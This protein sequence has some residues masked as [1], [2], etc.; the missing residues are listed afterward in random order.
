MSWLSRLGKKEALKWCAV[1]LFC[2]CIMGVVVIPALFLL[3]VYLTA[4]QEFVR[5]FSLPWPHKDGEGYFLSDKQNGR[6]VNHWSVGKP[7]FTSLVRFGAFEADHSNIPSKDILDSNLPVLKPNWSEPFEVIKA[8]WIGHA[9]VWVD[10]KGFS[11]LTDPI[12]S[13]RASPFSWSGPKRY[14]PPS[15]SISELPDSLDAVVISHSHYDHCDLP[16]LIELSQRYGSDLKWFVPSGLKPWML[17]NVPDTNEGNVHEMEWWEEY[18][19][20]SK[21]FK[22]AFTPSDHWSRRG[23]FDQNKVLWGSWVIEGK[24]QRVFFGGDTAYNTEAFKQIRRK[25]GDFD[26]GLI[27]IGAYNPRWFMQ[28]V[29]INPEEA[30]KIHEDIGAKKSLGIHW[31]TFKLTY[32][33]YLEPKSRLRELA[34]EK[35]IDFFTVNIGESLLYP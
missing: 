17:Y 16:S 23:I 2:G 26:V 11:V 25:Y 15:C 7:G 1:C 34:D 5:D 8:I 3:G 6:W 10:F 4:G 31:G 9:T 30:I 12:F 21:G 20:E 33:P 27:P 13:D 18:L 14:R 28:Y 19:F 24:G 35:G 29:H 22:I 32:E